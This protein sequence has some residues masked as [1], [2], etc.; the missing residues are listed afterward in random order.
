MIIASL[1]VVAAQSQSV[2][3]NKKKGVEPVAIA[4]VFLSAS[5]MLSDIVAM[6]GLAKH[7]IALILPHLFI[8]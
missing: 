7:R 8:S 1:A 5:M 6:F 4:V 2:S 3:D